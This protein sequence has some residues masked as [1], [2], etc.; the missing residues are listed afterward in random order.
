[1]QLNAVN[2]EIKPELPFYIRLLNWAASPFAV[3]TGFYFKGK[4]AYHC[5]P[6]GVLT[7]VGILFL[8]A[9]FIVLFGPVIIGSTIQSELK[10]IP[11][12]TPA[13]IPANDSVPS[14]LAQFFGR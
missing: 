10:I 11:F 8:F 13:D 3:E 5:Q 2:Q 4:K 1:M 6:C 9:S 12:N 14:G 7:L